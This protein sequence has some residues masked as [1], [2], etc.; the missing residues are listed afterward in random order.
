MNNNLFK[1]NR[2]TALFIYILVSILGWYGLILMT[3]NVNNFKVSNSQKKGLLLS[4][5]ITFLIWLKNCL[6][7][8]T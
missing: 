6:T 1:K 7:I 8:K 5:L 4:L 3:N 2:I